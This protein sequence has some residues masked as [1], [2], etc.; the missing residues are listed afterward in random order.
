MNRADCQFHLNDVVQVSTDCEYMQYVAGLIFKIQ[1][2]QYHSETQTWLLS[3]YHDN[4]RY[5][6]VPSFDCKL[7]QP[8]KLSREAA[9]M[10]VSET[11]FHPENLIVDKRYR[12]VSSLGERVTAYFQ[13][14]NSAKI[15]GR[16][17]LVVFFSARRGN[18]GSHY[19][20]TAAEV[21]ECRL[22]PSA[23][24]GDD[25]GPGEEG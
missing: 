7:I 19:S 23:G 11:P 1:R 10:A 9:R 18:I 15:G 2:I 8:G 24:D 12:V 17:R 20:L 4:G 21:A 22:A 3:G 13:G 14:L 16:S 5:L 25:C 6:C